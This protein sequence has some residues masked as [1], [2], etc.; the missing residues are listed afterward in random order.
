[1]MDNEKELA[2]YGVSN[3]PKDE[4]AYM[5][6]REAAMRSEK[7]YHKPLLVCYSGGKDSDT[8]VQLAIE[9][10][11]DLVAI[12]DDYNREYKQALYQAQYFHKAIISS[13]LFEFDK[14]RIRAAILKKTNNA[15]Q[16]ADD[17]MN[18][19]N[20]D[21]IEAAEALQ[22]SDVQHPE[23]LEYHSVLLPIQEELQ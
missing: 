2:L 11:I 21:N 15:R 19:L 23:N 17:S 22:S 4:V 14:D 6:L 3:L 18:W 20:E 7:Y 5:R 10:G 16:Y 1:M 8:L 13:F 9:S 12:D